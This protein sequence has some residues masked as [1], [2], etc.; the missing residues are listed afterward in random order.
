MMDAENFE[1]I[2]RYIY[3]LAKHNALISAG[4][5]SLLARC[6]SGSYHANFDIANWTCA[7]ER[8]QTALMAACFVANDRMI[9]LLLQEAADLSL[10]DQNGVNA[11]MMY[12]LRH[13]DVS[14]GFGQLGVNINSTT[15]NEFSALMEVSVAG[16]A[17]ALRSLL[18]MPGI[19]VNYRNATGHTGLMM[20][21]GAGKIENVEVLLKHPG[22]DVNIVDLTGQTC[23][24]LAA[25]QGNLAIVQALLAHGEID[26]NH[27]TF[28]GHTALMCASANNFPDVV[29]TLLRH[30][31][32]DVTLRS[33]DG[34]T[35]HDMAVGNNSNR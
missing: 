2:A 8:H 18:T 26:V 11:F 20:A 14:E 27:Q 22:I 29:Q 3:Q 16:S 13:E 17:G 30:P 9:R 4:V 5:R 19:D 10:E 32:V 33:L 24:G 28:A 34:R 7:A 25:A 23:L 15:H 6:F 12:C 35:F 1:A 31:G 21:V